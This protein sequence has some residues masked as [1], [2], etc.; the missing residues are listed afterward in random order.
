MPAAKGG[1]SAK[2][3]SGIVLATVC[4]KD[5]TPWLA[6]QTVHMHLRSAWQQA[7]A[8]RAGLYIILPDHLYVFARD[9]ASKMNPAEWIR[10][11]QSRFNRLHCKPSLRWAA[12]PATRKLKPSESYEHAWNQ[13][14]NEPVMEG[15]VKSAT[16]WPFQGEVFNL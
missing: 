5:H 2:P 4:T 1:R 6:D 7:V 3:A 12:E 13:L 15:L 11:W 10:F 14:R 8:W 16:D 9:D